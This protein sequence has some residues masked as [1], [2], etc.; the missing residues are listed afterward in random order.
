MKTDI[1]SVYGS[2][3]L[4]QGICRKCKSRFFILDK[5]QNRY[6]CEDCLAEMNEDELKLVEKSKGTKVV[7]HICRKVSRYIPKKTR[8]M[9]YERDDYKCVYCGKDLY[10]DFIC[11]TSGITVDHFFP[12][13]KGGMQE[14]DNLNTCCAKCNS[15]KRD[16][17]F[18]TIEDFK[19]YLKERN[20]DKK[21]CNS[22]N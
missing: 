16:K 22:D 1:L 8:L 20:E 6:Y 5:K 14:I 11:K 13:I 10:D 18:E 9:V 21:I 17:L 12:F 4:N 2:V 7:F 3:K 15:V 19:Q